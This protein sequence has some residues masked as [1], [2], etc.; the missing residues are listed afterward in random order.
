MSFFHC[1]EKQNLLSAKVESKRVTSQHHHRKLE[2][3]SESVK[4]LN[5]P[6]DVLAAA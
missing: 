5:I 2:M 1:E 6:Q 4:T 3:E